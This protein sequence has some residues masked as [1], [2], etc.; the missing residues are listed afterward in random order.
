M[1]KKQ[2][3]LI[4]GVCSEFTSSRVNSLDLQLLINEGF[5]F[6][7]RFPYQ[8]FECILLAVYVV[9]KVIYLNSIYSF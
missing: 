3:A 4:E 5:R 7:A 6:D 8:L 1:K 9:N 2:R